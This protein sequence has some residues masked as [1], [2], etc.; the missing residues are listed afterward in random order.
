M[1]ERTIEGGELLRIQ[2]SVPINRWT[3][4][5]AL[6]ND[7]ETAK[8]SGRSH[9]DRGGLAALD[10]RGCS[11]TAAIAQLCAVSGNQTCGTADSENYG[12]NGN[13]PGYPILL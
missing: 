3:Q 6:A 13:L 1:P 9:Q 12:S 4:S 5:D 11:R 2:F 7:R 10:E 8:G